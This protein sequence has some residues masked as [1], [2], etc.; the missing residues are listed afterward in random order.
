[1][2]AT[3]LRLRSAHPRHA[4]LVAHVLWFRC[5]WIYRVWLVRTGSADL[6][7]RM[8]LN[9]LRYHLDR[10]PIA[11]DHLIVFAVAS[12]ALVSLAGLPYSHPAGRLQQGLWF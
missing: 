9:S 6:H 10:D 1:M 7:S 2:R 5:R 12:G 4:T 11:Q 8:S 3:R